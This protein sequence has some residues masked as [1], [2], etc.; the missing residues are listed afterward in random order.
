[1]LDVVLADGIEVKRNPTL[2]PF[3]SFP[4]C[5]FIDHLRETEASPSIELE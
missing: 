4:F 2:Y 1:M 3:P 5:E